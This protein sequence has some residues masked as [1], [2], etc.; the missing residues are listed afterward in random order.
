MNAKVSKKTTISLSLFLLSPVTSSFLMPSQLY[1]FAKRIESGLQAVGVMR[2]PTNASQKL[3]N[4]S[5]KFNFASTSASNKINTQSSALTEASA[6]SAFSED[7]NLG[8]YM[9][10][11]VENYADDAESNKTD[12]FGQQMPISQKQ[13][14]ERGYLRK[15]SSSS[16]KRRSNSVKFAETASPFVRHYNHAFWSF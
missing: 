10:T 4:G 8:S 5:S 13:R 9:S 2:S 7:L 11:A 1:G 16:K 14:S 15:H 6:D 3:N 12:I